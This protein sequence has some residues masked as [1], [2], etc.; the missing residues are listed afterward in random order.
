VQGG[1]TMEKIFAI[2]GIKAKQF[3]PWLKCDLIM[4]WQAMTIDQV[5]VKNYVSTSYQRVPQDSNQPWR[6]DLNFRCNDISKEKVGK[7]HKEIMGYDLDIDPTKFS[8]RAVCKSNENGTHDGKIIDCPI[9]PEEIES[10]VVYNVLVENYDGQYVTDFRV[11]YMRGI[12]DIFSEKKH[13]LESRFTTGD[14]ATLRYIG[15][16]FST[17]EINSIEKFCIAM[18]ADYGELDIMRD[19]ESKRIYILDF[20]ATPMGMPPSSSLPRKLRIKLL[21]ELSFAF[22]KRVLEPLC[23]KKIVHEH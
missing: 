11:H 12:V 21:E 10:N 17:A 22:C 19:A 7:L 3:N 4:N 5:L 18:G 23:Q 9:K 1:Y 14:K 8:G 15:D 13:R 6:G 16:E 2:C 20:A